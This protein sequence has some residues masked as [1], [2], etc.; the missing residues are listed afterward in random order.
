MT[1]L[2][3]ASAVLWALAIAV[4]AVDGLYFHLWKYRLHARAESWTEHLTHLGRAF[5]LPPTLWLAFLL[6]A[7][8]TA[9]ERLVPLIAL[10]V[11][12]AVLGLWDVMLE[13]ASRRALGGLQRSE[14]LVHV[15]ATALHSGAEALAVA[16]WALAATGRAA[17]AIREP[18]FARALASVLLPAAIAAALLHAALLYPRFRAARRQ[19]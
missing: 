3:S 8:G 4:G 17:F 12:D 5:L 15:V 18:V 19:D 1:P 6:G 11:L 10:I 2:L 16:A 7:A 13:T 9:A 14:Y